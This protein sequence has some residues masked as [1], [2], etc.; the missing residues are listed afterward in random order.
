MRVRILKDFT[1][2]DRNYRAGESVEIED[3][4]VNAFGAHGLAMQDKSL[5]AASETKH[6]P[7]FQ[8]HFEG[9]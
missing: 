5:D 4:Q 1:I 2:W 7:V 3:W 8:E 9:K 6:R